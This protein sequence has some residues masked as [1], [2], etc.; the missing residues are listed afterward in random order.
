[1]NR[2][3]DWDDDDYMEWADRECLARQEVDRIEKSMHR[4]KAEN[5]RLEEN[6]EPVSIE[7]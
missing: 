4:R 5:Y 2:R 3:D 6:N 7:G 1:M